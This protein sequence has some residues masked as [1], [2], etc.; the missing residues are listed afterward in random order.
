MRQPIPGEDVGSPHS[1]KLSKCIL[2]QIGVSQP[3]QNSLAP[4]S[5]KVRTESHTAGVTSL[6]SNTPGTICRC[7]L[8][9][10]MVTPPCSNAVVISHFGEPHP[11]EYSISRFG[12]QLCCSSACLPLLCLQLSF[13]PRS[14]NM[15]LPAILGDSPTRRQIDSPCK[16]GTIA[17]SV[18]GPSRAMICRMASWRPATGQR[19]L[20]VRSAAIR[21]L[22]YLMAHCPADGRFVDAKLRRDLGTCQGR[23]IANPV[24]KK[25]VLMT[26]EEFTHTT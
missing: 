21:Q 10:V 25:G 16:R 5:A 4:V 8:K 13:F 24:P 26:D 20:R 14:R 9:D 6:H 7:G 1:N 23:K 12:Q 19:D 11:G 3:R 18:S 17:R 15:K 2:R 22:K